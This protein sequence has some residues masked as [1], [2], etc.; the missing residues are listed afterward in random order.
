MA[1]TFVLGD[2]VG[3]SFG[4]VMNASKRQVI[5]PLSKPSVASC[6][7]DENNPQLGNVLTRDLLLRVY[8]NSTL[9]FHGPVVATEA[10]PGEQ[11]GV[12]VAITAADPSFRLARRVSGKSASPA[13]ITSDKG[14]IA[15]QIIDTANSDGET[16]VR[17]Q[18]TSIGYSGVYTP[19]P[20]KYT[21]SCI[22]ELADSLDGFNW[23]IT[24]ME[25][26]SGK[27][28]TF[29]ANWRGNYVVKADVVFEYGGIRSNIR[30]FNAQRS[31]NDIANKAYHIPD[32]GPASPLTVLSQS[33]GTSIGGRGL[34]E[35][36]LEAS[37]ILDPTL[38]N[39]LLAEVV[40]A[41]KDPRRV[42]TFT[43]D[44]DDPGRPGRV[45][46]FGAD[47]NVGDGVRV[48]INPTGGGRPSTSAFVDGYLRIYS[49]QIDIDNNG[50]ATYTPITVDEAPATA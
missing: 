35:T 19:G 29:V 36:I 33:D 30:T 22:N 4:E 32:D 34:Y 11:G 50:R 12:Q 13:A 46:V 14:D 6:V 44:F 9:R 23:Q 49:M 3:N 18:A 41:R 27:I 37:S 20:Y 8:D 1:Y 43:P 26:T 7:I 24:P 21:L 16:G 40:G 25:Y 17:T 48:R 28:G 15:K 38:R 10:T 39:Q 45:P 47:Y 42:V 5:L 31:W 2:L